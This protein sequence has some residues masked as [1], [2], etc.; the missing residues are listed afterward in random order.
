MTQFLSVMGGIIVAG[1]GA[2]LYFFRRGGIYNPQTPVEPLPE[3][4]TVPPEAVLP[5]NP[6]LM[7][8]KATLANFLKYQWQFEGAVPANKNPGNYKFFYGDYAPVYGAVKRSVGGFAMFP[9]LQQGQLYAINCTKGVIKHHPEL[10]ILTYL[11]GDKDWS[12]YAPS[13]DNNNPLEYATFIAKG[14]EVGITFLMK[15]L[16]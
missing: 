9:T 14:L 16:V 6:P 15:D 10:T 13:G 11:G 12:G 3:A 1:I 8:P 4:P 5:I 7:Q 2:T